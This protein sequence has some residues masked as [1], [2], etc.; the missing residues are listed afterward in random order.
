MPST[1]VV[2]VYLITGQVATG[3]LVTVAP[4]VSMLE[5]NESSIVGIVHTVTVPKV[6][7]PSGI[8]SF[9]LLGSLD[10]RVPTQYVV[11]VGQSIY[12]VTLPDGTHQLYDLLNLPAPIFLPAPPGPGDA[13]YVQYSQNGTTWSDSTIGITTHVRLASGAVRPASID[14]LWS[15]PIPLSAVN[16]LTAIVAVTNAQLKTLDTD[17]VTLI[18]APGIGSYIQLEQLWVQKLGDD[19]L[20]PYNPQYRFW[21]SSSATPVESEALA[22]QAT[23]P[24]R[25]AN[26]GQFT[27]ADWSGE[28]RYV[29][30]G[31]HTSRYPE[32][33]IGYISA[34][35]IAVWDG[36]PSTADFTL[37]TNP[38]EVD[39]EDFWIWRSNIAYDSLSSFTAVPRIALDPRGYSINSLR[40]MFAAV[41]FENLSNPE[42]PLL[43]GSALPQAS[44][45]LTWQLR[46]QLLRAGTFIGAYATG[47]QG[48]VENKPLLFGNTVNLRELSADGRNQLG[49]LYDDA[50]APVQDVSLT[51]FLRYTI[52]SIYQFA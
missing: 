5:V 19:Q 27:P 44:R 47:I 33:R 28:D 18:P 31:F 4:V 46:T 49:A 12:T 36:T 48:L 43:I 16:P 8:V 40:G 11:T 52:H 35:Y 29:Y 50:I 3:V 45:I 39:G 32:A 20:A 51:F 10:Y 1:L 7:G 23:D 37:L 13:V 26:P 38:V 2:D 30:I 22:G 24:T 41:L 14:N 9:D 6:T 17:Y 34:N 25:N 21:T 42:Y 15:S